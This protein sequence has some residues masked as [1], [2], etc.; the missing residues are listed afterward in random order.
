MK[1]LKCFI[2]KALHDKEV[3]YSAIAFQYIR[4]LRFAPL[5]T[6]FMFVRSLIND[7]KSENDKS[8]Y[9]KWVLGEGVVKRLL[10]V[11]DGGVTAVHC[12]PPPPP[13]APAPPPPSRGQPPPR[14]RTSPR[15]PECL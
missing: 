10:E 7:R 14:C 15:P 2:R 6:K 9:H 8:A 13:G 4:L 3:S 5:I 12:V 1:G 11:L